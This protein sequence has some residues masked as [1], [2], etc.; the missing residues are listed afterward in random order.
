M[1][2]TDIFF[3]IESVNVFIEK[4]LELFDEPVLAYAKT[5]WLKYKEILTSAEFSPLKC[6]SYSNAVTITKPFN[7]IL[8]APTNV[9]VANLQLHEL[10]TSFQRSKLDSRDEKQDSIHLGPWSLANLGSG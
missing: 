1:A 5:E 3:V 10:D 8:V 7:P 4:L 2:A 6:F 9:P